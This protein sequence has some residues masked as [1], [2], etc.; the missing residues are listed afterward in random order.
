MLPRGPRGVVH[1]ILRNNPQFTYRED[2]G[3]S[4]DATGAQGDVWDLYW[5]DPSFSKDAIG[6]EPN[7]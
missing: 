6:V 4:L 2:G 3:Q 7:L 1:D 5:R